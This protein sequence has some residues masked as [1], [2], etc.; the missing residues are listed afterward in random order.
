MVPNE[1]VEI[2]REQGLDEEL[3]FRDQAHLQNSYHVNI[4]MDREEAKKL[5]YENGAISVSYYSKGKE[6]YYNDT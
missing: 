5:I 4:Q 6:K 1:T 2:V 3:A